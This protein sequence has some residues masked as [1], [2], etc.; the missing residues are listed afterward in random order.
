[1]EVSVSAYELLKKESTLF[2]KGTED[3]CSSA[4]A[5]KAQRAQIKKELESARGEFLIVKISVTMNDSR[6]SSFQV[7]ISEKAHAD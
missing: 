5:R 4:G 6:Y 2:M 1:M 3:L 7:A